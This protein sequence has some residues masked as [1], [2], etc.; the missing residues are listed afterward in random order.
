M[1]ILKIV[2]RNFFRRSR[3]R[4]PG[5]MP[6][7]PEGFRGMMSHE[8]ELCTACGTCA[9]VCSS[10]AIKIDAEISGAAWS[11]DG[12]QCT[13]CGNCERYC[14]TK[15]IRLERRPAPVTKDRSEHRISHK[16]SYKPC[17]RCGRPVVPLAE[18]VLRMLYG[19]GIPANALSE[20]SLCEECRRRASVGHIKDGFLGRGSEGKSKESDK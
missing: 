5:D 3:T 7:F 8:A 18:K 20:Q 11:F 14:P 1:A 10:S 6:A 16:I 13:F 2:F 12:G 19:T 4:R 15:A 9:Y 17:P